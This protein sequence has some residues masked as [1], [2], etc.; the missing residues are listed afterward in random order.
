MFEATFEIRAAWNDSVLELVLTG[1]A[2]KQNAA[3]IARDVFQIATD[4]KPERLLIDVT[5]LEGRLG[6][7]DTFFHVQQYPVQAVKSPKTAVLDLTENSIYYSFHETVAA[8]AGMSLRYFADRS[9]AEL[10]VRT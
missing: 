7:T 9:A 5:A 4:E 2:S 3:E 1:Q 6:F 8:N 10:W